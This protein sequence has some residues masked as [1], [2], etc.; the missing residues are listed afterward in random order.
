MA[1]EAA[2]IFAQLGNPMVQQVHELL[3]EL[4]KDDTGIPNPAQAAFED[5]QLVASP[6]EM[7]AVIAKYPFMADDGF[8]QAV[9][10]TISTVI[11]PN[12]QPAFE[13]RLAWLKQIA[14]K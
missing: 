4:Q 3:I 7:I 10:Q 5:F 12:L 2:R 13:Q 1:K 11:P 6:E 14:G 9:E 8:L